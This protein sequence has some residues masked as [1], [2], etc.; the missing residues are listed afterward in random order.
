MLLVK[1]KMTL[2]YLGLFFFEFVTKS[3]WIKKYIVD[4][5]KIIQKKI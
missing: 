1:A 2:E 5:I 3:Q 4:S